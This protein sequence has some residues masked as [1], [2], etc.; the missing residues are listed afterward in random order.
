MDTGVSLKE[1]SKVKRQR[2]STKFKQEAARLM[3]MDGLGAPE[4][5]E[6]LGVNRGLF[7][8]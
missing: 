4:E 8:R 3:I 2:Y 5:S 6:K 1:K 7:Y